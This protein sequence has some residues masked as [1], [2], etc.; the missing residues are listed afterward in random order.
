MSTQYAKKLFLSHIFYRYIT[1]SV[2]NRIRNLCEIEGSQSNFAEKTGIQRQTVSRIVNR[3]T[4]IRSDTIEAIAIAYPTLSLRWLILGEEPMW[5]VEEESIQ[6]REH[7]MQ[8]DD[9]MKMKMIELLETK[10]R[11]LQR[12]IKKL[13]PVLARELG[14]D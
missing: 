8:S 14:L 5:Q 10:V 12:E 13:D 4:G 7:R 9:E 2:A 3:N 1:M 11:V 6:G